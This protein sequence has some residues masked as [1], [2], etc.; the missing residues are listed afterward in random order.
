MTMKELV[1]M[2]NNEENFDKAVGMLQMLNAIHGNQ[3]G[4]LNRRVVRFDNPCGS[5]AEKYSGCHDLLCEL[6]FYESL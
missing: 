2:I 3:Y 5:V 4:L 6:R 1:Q